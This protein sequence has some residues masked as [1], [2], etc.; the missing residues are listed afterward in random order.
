MNTAEKTRRRPKKRKWKRELRN[1]VV[2]AIGP[3]LLRAWMWTLRIRYVD[4]GCQIR[5]MP[6]GRSHGVYV[7]W[8]QRMLVF[9]ALYRNSDVRV[10]ISQHGDGD[11][12]ARVVERLGFRPVRGSSTRGGI[13]ATLEMLRQ[14]TE[15]VTIAITP[16]GPRGPRHAFQEGAIYI[17]SRTGMPIYLVAVSCKRHVQLPTWDGF[18]LPCPF[19]AT[20]VRIAEPFEVPRNADRAGIE[21]ARQEA[22]RRLRELTETTDRNV[23]ELFRTGDKTL[24]PVEPEP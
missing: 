23:A 20:V 4:I 15:G 13:R 17:A 2:A 12:I 5:G 14:N 16:D 19:T 18:I 11:M 1:F 6:W 24:P 8:H 10:L 22:E 9:A 21:V 7:F 3:A